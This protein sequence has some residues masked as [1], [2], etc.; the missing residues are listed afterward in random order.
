MLFHR[1]I[2]ENWFYLLPKIGLWLFLTIFLVGVL[3]VFLL[4]KKEIERLGS[5]PLDQDEKPRHDH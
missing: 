1:I 3:R 2:F 4:P 5:L